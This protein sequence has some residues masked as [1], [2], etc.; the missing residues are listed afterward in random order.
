M[1]LDSLVRNA[2]YFFLIIRLLNLLGEN[3][4]GGYYLAMHIF[5]SFLLVPI[6]ALSES[7][8]VLVAKPAIGLLLLHPS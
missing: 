6:L 8:K 5:W 3:A 1:G 4:I 7:L 2:A